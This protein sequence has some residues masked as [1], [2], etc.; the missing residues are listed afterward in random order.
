MM[1]TKQVQVDV[2]SILVQLISIPTHVDTD[3][4]LLNLLVIR[5]SFLQ[6][7]KRISSFWL[8]LL[9]PIK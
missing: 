3:T 9:L 8:L 6:K 7:K 2:Y 5:I 1:R 4:L